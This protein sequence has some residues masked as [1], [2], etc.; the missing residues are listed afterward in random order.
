MTR[1]AIRWARSQ[2]LVVRLLLAALLI[3]GALVAFVLTLV[4]WGRIDWLRV[5]EV[6][7]MVAV[8]LVLAGLGVLWW[9]ARVI[10]AMD[11][12]QR[13]ENE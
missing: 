8:V 3:T 5:G 1:G 6:I 10:H 9:G 4:L 12:E 2:S 13:R 11:D 7:G